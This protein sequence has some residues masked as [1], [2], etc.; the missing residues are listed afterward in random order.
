[1]PVD[2]AG[3]GAAH[4]QTITVTASSTLAGTLYLYISGQLVAVP[5]A[6]SDAQNTIAAT[7]NTYINANNNLPVTSTVSTNVVTV[8]AKNKGVLSNDIDIRVN[9]REL[10]G[11]EKYPGGVSVAV[12]TTVA[13][14]TDPSTIANAI[15]AI[16]EESY[17][18]VIWPWTDD[19]NMDLIEAEMDRRWLPGVKLYGHVFAC[20][21]DVLADLSTYGTARNSQHSTVFGVDD[22]PS[23]PY[24][25]AAAHVGAVATRIS[26]NP[27]R[28]THGL[29]VRTVLP[30]SFS[31]NK[32]F[33]NTEMETLLYDGISPLRVQER[34]ADIYTSRM[35]TTYQTNAADTPDPS[36]LDITTMFT[37]SAVCKSLDAALQQ[38]FTGFSIVDDGNRLTEFQ[39]S[40]SHIKSFVVAHFKQLQDQGLVENIDQFK[41]DIR[42]E[43]AEDPTRVNILWPGN[44]ANPLYVLAVNVQFR[45]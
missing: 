10:S 8:T 31:S 19:T 39:T 40:P 38:E 13:G 16:P 12:A 11:G 37:L 3:G 43:R 23:A 41:R 14:S 15:A 28:P 24:E 9:Y 7:I 29:K 4:A 32:R 22:S 20:V 18:F 1:I 27:A 5:V 2:D 35:I 44:L 21:D 33:Q 17:D 6:A 45:L 25:I 26:N 36:Y 30:P 42:V 34:T